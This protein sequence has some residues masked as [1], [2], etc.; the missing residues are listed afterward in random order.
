MNKPCFTP[1]LTLALEHVPNLHEYPPFVTRQ[2]ATFGPDFEL[3]KSR[4]G[5]RLRIE[6]SGE[7]LL[8]SIC[9]LTH[10]GPKQ[11]AKG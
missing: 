8:R 6:P 3:A 9:K 1:T 4:S 5:F 2:Q 10:V 7:S 11:Y